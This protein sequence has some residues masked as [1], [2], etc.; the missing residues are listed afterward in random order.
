VP[1]RPHEE[2]AGD[3]LR[4]A[5]LDAVLGVEELIG[6]ALSN[7]P[8]SANPSNLSARRVL[9]ADRFPDPAAH[10]SAPGDPADVGPV[11]IEA[12]ARAER[13][14]PPPAGVTIVY[15]EDDGPLDR[16]RALATL[17]A[18]RHGHVLTVAGPDD[19]AP[20]PAALAPAACRLLA[21]PDA[22][23]SPLST[24]PRV[25]TAARRLAGLAGRESVRREA[26]REMLTRRA[27]ASNRA[28]AADDRGPKQRR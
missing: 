24:D 15:R 17:A 6:F 23:L 4:F 26:W 16:A 11:R 5:T 8:A 9:V 14:S 25:L 19:E 2:A 22:M 18:R 27:K 10:V 3:R 12:G 28:P 1:P 7:R 20:S 21:E 13:A